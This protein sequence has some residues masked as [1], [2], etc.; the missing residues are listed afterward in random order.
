VQHLWSR[1]DVIPQGFRWRC[2]TKV[3][4]DKCSESRSIKHG[5][6]IQQSHLTFHEI[7]HITYDIVR[8]EPVHYIQKEY[9]VLALHL[10]LL[11]HV[12]PRLCRLLF[13]HFHYVTLPAQHSYGYSH[14]YNAVS[15]A[16]CADGHIE[17]RIVKSP[18]FGYTCDL[19]RA[20]DIVI[21]IDVLQMY[22]RSKNLGTTRKIL[23]L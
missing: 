6:W 16:S 13:R 23:A 3:P 17:S 5:S 4:R 9:V 18:Q 19:R 14:G 21:C 12:R 10:H 20:Y 2:R 7:L 11:L 22:T 1:Y 15:V 8:R